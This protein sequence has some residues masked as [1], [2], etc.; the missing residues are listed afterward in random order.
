MM[1]KALTLACAVLLTALAL[2][3]GAEAQ[4]PANQPRKPRCNN[5]R[6]IARVL[7]LTPDQV[8][9]SRAIYDELRQTVE[10]L[11]GQ[12]APLREALEDLLDTA[13]PNACDVGQAVV[14]I[15]VIHDQIDDARAAAHE[16]F[17]GLL[18]PA[19]LDRW[20]TFQQNCRHGYQD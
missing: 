11:R 5:L 12:I 18:T 2:P 20:E 7:Q 17:E 10:P 19:Q 13:S 4:P 14:D 15:D 3:Q 6:A 1:K 9:Q 16:E 8:T